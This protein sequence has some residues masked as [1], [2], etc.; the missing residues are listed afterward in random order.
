MGYAKITHLFH[1]FHGQSFQVLKIKN[2]SG[3]E[4]VS[5]KHPQRGSFAVPREWTDQSEPHLSI[6]LGGLPCIL[7]PY[8]LLELTE[9]V[10]NL[11][12]E[13]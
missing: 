8:S 4:T 1:P 13:S 11:N 6:L 10:Q 7:E 3:V 5:L 2:I 12:K 9:L